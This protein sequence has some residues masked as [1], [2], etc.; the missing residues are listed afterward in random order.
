MT[1]ATLELLCFFLLLKF[2]DRKMFDNP[3]ESNAERF[4]VN[5]EFRK[6]MKDAQQ[7]VK[8]LLAILFPALL[9]LSPTSHLCII[10]MKSQSN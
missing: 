8:I 9:S 5:S 2:E 6:V 10:I 7:V 4:P 1:N 3:E